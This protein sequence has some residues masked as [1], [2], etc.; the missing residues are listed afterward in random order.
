MRATERPSTCTSAVARATVSSR[1]RF[2]GI[3]D[4]ANKPRHTKMA[5]TSST[6]VTGVNCAVTGAC[7]N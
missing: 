7:G 5:V 2:P 3:L 1:C 6:L 4:E